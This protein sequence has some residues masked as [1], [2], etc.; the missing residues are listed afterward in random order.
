MIP[1]LYLHGRED[2]CMSA[3]FARWIG[4]V[5]PEGSDVAVVDDAGH[6]HPL[7]QRT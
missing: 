4:S 5:L 7:E 1:T 2:G 3:E 6:F